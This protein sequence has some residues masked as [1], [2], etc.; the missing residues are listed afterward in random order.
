MTFGFSLYTMPLLVAL[1]IYFRKDTQN[2][3]NEQVY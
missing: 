2:I 1:I 3:I